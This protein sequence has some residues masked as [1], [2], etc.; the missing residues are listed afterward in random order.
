MLGTLGLAIVPRASAWPEQTA[1]VPGE[2]VI[3][4]EGTG[5][6]HR[7]GCP[8][9]RSG[10]GVL[11]LSRAQADGRGLK[12]HPDCDPSSPASG[13]VR[14]SAPARPGPEPTVTV[15]VEGPRYYHRHKECSRLESRSAS[16]KAV[17]LETA[18]KSHWPCPACKAPVFKRN[19]EPAV[20]GTN[21]RRGR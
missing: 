8:V 7:P 2:L 20:P 13:Q 11:A 18:A 16:A 1:A 12:P 15:Y 14:G 10:E 4:K 3:A 6:Y 17:T 21:R 9:V 5:Q 19:T